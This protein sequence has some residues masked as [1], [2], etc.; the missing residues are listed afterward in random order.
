MLVE[1]LWE[2]CK[3]NV[4]CTLLELEAGIVYPKKLYLYIEKTQSCKNF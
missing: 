1:N 2:E 3:D 4:V